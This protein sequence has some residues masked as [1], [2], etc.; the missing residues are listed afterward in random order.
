VNTVLKQKHLG[1]CTL[2]SSVY[3]ERV[4][5]VDRLKQ[6]LIEVWPGLQQTIVNEVTGEQKKKFLGL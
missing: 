2:Y 1:L 5:N 3:T 6:R 4:N